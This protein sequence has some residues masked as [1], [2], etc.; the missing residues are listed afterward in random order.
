MLRLLAIFLVAGAVIAGAL[1]AASLYSAYHDLRVGT[2]ISR[3]AA[4][5]LGSDP[6]NWTPAVVARAAAEADRGQRLV[7]VGSRRF[8]SD[9]MLEG[10]SLLPYAGDQPRAVLD[11]ADAASQAA[12]A[13]RDAV[14]VARLYS[15][16]A[17]GGGSPARFVGVLAEASPLLLDA[18]ARLRSALDHVNRDRGG[19]L[20]PQLANLM[21]SAAVTLAAAV[22]QADGFTRAARLVPPAL[23]DPTPRTYLLVLPNPTELRPDGGYAGIVGTITFDHGAPTAI[24]LIDEITL[25][26]RYK[27]VE[28]VPPAMAQH[29]VIS[30]NTLSIA[31][32]GW[33][34]DLPTSA[35]V[36]EK[37][38]VSAT[39]QPV[40]GTMLVDPY[41]IQALLKITGPVTVPGYGAFTGDDFLARI[42]VL[43]NSAKASKTTAVPAIS[44]Q[45][46]KALLSQP[47]AT[48]PKLASAIVEQG[49]ERHIQVFAHERGVEAA[50]ADEGLD[51]SIAATGLNDYLMVVDANLAA[52]KGDAYI[53]KQA[54]LR[55]EMPSSGLANHEVRLTYHFN[56]PRTQADKDLA[57]AWSP[58]NPNGDY[59]DYVR[60]YVP[61]TSHLTGFR[62]LVDGKPA[63][64]SSVAA[65][66]VEHGKR[67]IAG[68]FDIAPGQTATVEMTYVAPLP[69]GRVYDV[70]LQKQAG[71]PS[72][73]TTVWLSH[74]GGQVKKNLD[75]VTDASFQVSW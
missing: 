28:P 43:I 20:A 17:T 3:Q 58:G 4:R 15:E 66:T 5:D 56:P 62:I 10:I 60:V 70:H 8:H 50:L 27:V 73:P 34:P 72:L 14:A 55:V 18:S 48:Y 61:E 53:T 22:D 54:E 63:D 68:Y 21:A 26:D 42:N 31:D 25:L 35:P 36:M 38:W 29:M 41:A 75:L 40:D 39:G 11:L 52:T 57:T 47:G 2:D 32:A 6:A 71:R 67:V 37:L 19:A 45:V 69:P 51:G 74:P 44:A 46:L 7:D 12:T 59:R 13:T 9:L 1:E 16:A 23:G 49:R 64:T 30:N 33:D 24:N 65:N